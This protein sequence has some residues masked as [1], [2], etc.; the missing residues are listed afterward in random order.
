MLLFIDD[1]EDQAKM[2]RLKVFISVNQGK[3]ELAEQL[4]LKSM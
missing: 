2:Y 3:F 4:Y 1:S